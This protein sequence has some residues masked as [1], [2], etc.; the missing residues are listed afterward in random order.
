MDD[1]KKGMLWGL[2]AGDCLGSP[3]QFTEKDKHPYITEMIACHYFSTPPGYWTDDSSMAFCIMESVVRLG[4]YDLE[5]IARNFVR[6]YDHGFWSSLDYAFDVGTATAMACIEI[7]KHGTLRNG[8]EDSQGNGSIM[9]FAPTFFL[10]RRN[11]GN[12][13]PH[14]ISDLTHNSSVVRRTIDLM[15]E[16]CAA[17]LR[18]KRTEHLSKYTSRDEVNNSGWAVSTV[19]AALWAFHSTRNFEDG[20]IAAVNLGGDADS[21]GAVYGQIAGAYYGFRAIP[22]RWLA[23]I[24]DRDRI[25]KLIADFLAVTENFNRTAEMQKNEI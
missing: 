13:I 24:K 10:N 2:V 12:R 9:R 8:F 3:I 14:E 25:E 6:W 17:H 21:I 1:R 4:G 5:D 15:T 19:Q 11:D 22:E 7:R 23:K 20:M 18:G 16:I